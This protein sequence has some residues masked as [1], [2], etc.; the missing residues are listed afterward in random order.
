MKT[1][2]LMKRDFMASQI[3]QRTLDKFFNA[4]ELLSIFNENSEI[5]K[6]LPEFWSNKNTKEFYNN[7]CLKLDLPYLHKATK[8]RGGAT[9]MHEDLLIVFYNWL[10]KL[11]NQ[12][13][14]RDEIEFVKYIKESFD[15]FLTFETQKRFGTYY[16]DLYCNELEL[17]IEFDEPHHKRK[18][19]I[20]LDEKRQKEIELKYNVSFIRHLSGD[21]F[22]LTINKILKLCKY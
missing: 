4:T 7:L 12:S 17:C 8:G 15:D 9:W 19:N 10:Y 1:N 5:K 20:F 21:R 6:V 14:T 18:S 22:S 3:T 16:V 2:Q 13:V 11:P